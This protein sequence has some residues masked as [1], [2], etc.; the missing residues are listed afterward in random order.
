ME[1]LQIN[2]CLHLRNQAEFPTVTKGNLKGGEG[3]RRNNPFA[4]QAN[5]SQEQ[6][7][8]WM[9]ESNVTCFCESVCFVFFS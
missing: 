7:L 3:E 9:S 5:V 2:V 1:Q 4:M 6:E 8:V